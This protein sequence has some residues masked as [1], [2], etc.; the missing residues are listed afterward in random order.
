LNFIIFLP[1]VYGKKNTPLLLSE[2]SPLLSLIKR[3]KP[4]QL[5]FHVNLKILALILTSTLLLRKQT[6]TKYPQDAFSSQSAPLNRP[7]SGHLNLENTQVDSIPHTRTHIIP[8]R[9]AR[10]SKSKFQD[11]KSFN[12]I[13]RENNSTQTCSD[14]PKQIPCSNYKIAP[15]FQ[16][17]NLNQM[18]QSKK[19]N[20]QMVF[21]ITPRIRSERKI[22][23]I[24][25]SLQ[26]TVNLRIWRTLESSHISN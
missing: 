17:L 24:M 12:G 8:K 7:S 19:I 25:V 16:R 5:S 23:I 2:V 10:C 21:L 14:P 26:E 1:L 20:R 3:E 22:Q 15:S 4:K 11:N 9:K 6:K 13:A 18:D